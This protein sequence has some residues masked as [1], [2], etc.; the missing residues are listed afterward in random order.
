MKTVIKRF[1]PLLLV[2]LILIAVLA[3]VLISNLRS[4]PEHA[5]E[6]YIRASLQYDADGLLKYASE[7]QLTALKGNVEMDLDTLRETLKTG[8]EQAIEYREKGKIT[9]ESEVKELI[10]PGT[11]AFGELLEEYAF[12]ADPSK[13]QEFA[14]VTARCYINGTLKRTYSAIAVRC[15]GKWYYG[16]IA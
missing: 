14:S 10:E 5:V 3:G 9:F 1:W 4:T 15:D 13:V 16:F 12:K 8:Y 11:D 7:Y 2:G 6:G